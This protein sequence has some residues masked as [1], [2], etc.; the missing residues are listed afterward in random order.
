MADK[1]RESDKKSLLESAV[2]FLRDE[3]VINA[4]LDEKDKLSAKKGSK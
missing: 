3:S 2:A 1:K 4:P